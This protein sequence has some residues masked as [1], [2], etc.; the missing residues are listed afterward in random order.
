MAIED[1]DSQ[2]T[3]LQLGF[4]ANIVHIIKADSPL[5]NLRCGSMC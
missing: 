1:L 5:Y 2:Q 3:N 4:P